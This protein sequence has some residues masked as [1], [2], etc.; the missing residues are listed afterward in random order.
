MANIHNSINRIS[1][2]KKPTLWVWI[3]FFALNFILFLPAYLFNRTE[4]SFF[5]PLNQ[6]FST[7]DNYD[8]FR[9]S[10]EWTIIAALWVNI[11]WLRQLWR[12]KILSVTLTV[13]YFIILIYHIYEN[14]ID[15]Y[16]HTRPNFYDDWLFVRSGIGFLLD[17]LRMPLW[18]FAV[19]A[20][21]GVGIVWGLAKMVRL[22]FTIPVTKIGRPSKLGLLALTLLIAILGARNSWQMANPTAEVSSFTAKLVE[23]AQGMAVSAEQVAYIT[24]FD[25]DSVY[26]YDEYRLR[27]TPNIYLIFVESYGSVLYSSVTLRRN[28]LPRIEAM[29]ATL[30][31]HG[32]HTA[33]TL[34]TSPTF[35]GGSWM[36]YTSAQYGI[37]V[38]KQSQYLTLR[39]KYQQTPYPSLGRYLQNQ[40]YEFV[41]VTPIARQLSPQESLENDQFYGPDRWLLF[42]DMNYV[43]PMY[44]W[45]PS[46]P[47]QFTLGFAQS[48]AEENVRQ[49]LFLFYL[50]QNSHYPWSPLPPVT[51]SWHDLNDSNI[52]SPPA[53]KQA[54]PYYEH[55]KN[56]MASIDYTLTTL[57]DFIVN[58]ADERAIFVLVG[59]HQPP[60]VARKRA[61]QATPV[62]II[63]KD[64]D[65]VAQFSTFGFE[66]GLELTDMTPKMHHEGL[67]AL[68]VRTLVARY[69]QNPTNLPPS[70]MQ[71]IAA[72]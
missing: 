23:N 56:Y 40:G 21:V 18:Y 8:I 26:N 64:A 5:P 72:P 19:G 66:D 10:V 63:S 44:G 20:I 41:W 9:L 50:T 33:S 1:P 35:G 3:L 15:T 12:R 67:Y 36:A 68:L 32:W 46:P 22:F 53:A 45:G 51:D 39:E 25:P 4:S 11:D 29:D 61:G 27:E 71:Q 42:D 37:R 52:E 30:R 28:Y 62:H 54:L 13:V 57:T 17:G 31:E 24:N 49:P 65:F 55:A 59:D 7:R 38:G 48:F 47:D 58:S 34:S 69:G 43:G 14:L 70:G 2:R 60:I 16:Y 6:L